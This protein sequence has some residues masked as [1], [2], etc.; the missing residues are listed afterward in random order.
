MLV[1]DTVGEVIGLHAGVG[2]GRHTEIQ[3]ITRGM[4]DLVGIARWQYH[5]IG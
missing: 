3:R 2:I 1:T 5:R 4:H